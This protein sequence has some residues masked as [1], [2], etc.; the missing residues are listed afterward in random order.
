MRRRIR[1]AALLLAAVM[2]LGGCSLKSGDELYS[3]PK[4]SSEYESLQQSIQSLLDSG[5]EYAAPLSG[6][7]TQAVQDVDLNGDGVS[8]VVAFLRNT[9]ESTLM[10]Y[11]F[12]QNDEGEYEVMTTI[13]GQGSAVNSVVY[14]QLD[15]EDNMEIVI[16][17]QVSTGV[18]A[19]SAYSVWS[20]GNLEL[21]AAQSYTRYSIVD[22]NDDG[23]DELLLLY[24]DTSDT[25]LNRAEYYTY[26]DGGLSLT[27]TARLSY[28][29]ASIDRIRS[30]DLYGGEAALYVTGYVVDTE[31]GA[32]SSS[33]QLTDILALKDGELVNVTLDESGSTSATTRRRTYVVDQDLN[34]DGIWEIP[35]LSRI[36]ERL[37]DGS[38]TVSENFYLVSWA[39]YDL[40]GESHVICS[41]Y[42]NS[43]DGWY[44]TLPENWSGNIAL[45]RSDYSVGETVE[46][47]IQFYALTRVDEEAGVWLQ[48]DESTG[49]S[50]LNNVDAELFMTI[51][52][53]TGD[54]REKRAVLGDRILLD[55]GSEDAVYSVELYETENEFCDWTAG[56]VL[57]NLHILTTD[58]SGD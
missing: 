22:L 17:W 8:E 55:T 49:I 25:S 15:G 30:A 18:Y 33:I 46:R 53:N 5:L 31:N 35:S 44:L 48:E 43:S 9:E 20:G 2:L 23:T 57:E 47:S 13:S 50:V 19:L 24:L 42:Y 27:G 11:L 3:L 14:S 12:Q 51:Y 36:Y 40:G 52:K 58:W 34:D 38:I 41:T 1:L 39:Q 45:K 4:M 54:D 28:D 7:N 29:L 56:D 10:V 16:T 21:M 26:S 6:S 32:A 37:D